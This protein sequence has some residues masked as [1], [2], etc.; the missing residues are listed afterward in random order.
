MYTKREGGDDHHDDNDVIIMV[1]MLAMI[2]IVRII[3][4]WCHVKVNWTKNEQGITGLGKARKKCRKRLK[5]CRRIR[6]T[7]VE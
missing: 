3:V 5:R 6:K 1:M 2:M 7:W 4:P